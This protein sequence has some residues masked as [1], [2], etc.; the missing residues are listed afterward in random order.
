MVTLYM[1]VVLKMMFGL[2]RKITV[3]SLVCFSD[4]SELLCLLDDLSVKDASY[5]LFQGRY[6]LVIVFFLILPVKEHAPGGL[7]W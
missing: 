1:R 5:N 7:V 6:G 4:F 2:K 3:H